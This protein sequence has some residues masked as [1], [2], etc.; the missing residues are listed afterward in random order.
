MYIPAGVYSVIMMV[1]GCRVVGLGVAPASSTAADIVGR[2]S[3]LRGV[4]R[5]SRW[6]SSSAVE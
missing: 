3:F 2:E 6:S 5:A 4:D 1:I